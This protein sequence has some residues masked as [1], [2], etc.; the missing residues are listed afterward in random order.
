MSGLYFA[1]KVSFSS[2]SMS[3]SGWLSRVRLACAAYLTRRKK[4]AK[5][6]LYF[7]GDSLAVAWRA[8]SPMPKP[9]FEALIGAPPAVECTAPRIEPSRSNAS[10]MSVF[11]WVSSSEPQVPANCMSRSVPDSSSS[12]RMPPRMTTISSNSR[13]STRMQVA[14]LATSAALS[15]ARLR[16]MMFSIAIVM[17]SSRLSRA[18]MAVVAASPFAGSE[19]VALPFEKR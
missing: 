12:G 11:A 2:F 16:V 18:A 10:G 8:L 5:S 9:G 14:N 6:S 13:S 4:S 3:T 17:N 15:C 7:S 19:P 1:A